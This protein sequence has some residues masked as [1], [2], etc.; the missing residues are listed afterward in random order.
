MATRTSPAPKGNSSGKSGS[1]SARGSGPAAAKTS[2]AGGTKAPRAPGSW[3]PSNPAA[4]AGP[5][6][7]PAP[8]WASPTSSGRVSGGSAT[9]SATSPPRTAATAPPCSTWRWRL[10]RHLRLVG[11]PGWFPDI[12]YAVVNGTFGWMSLV[13][14]LMLF[15]C[16]FRLFRQPVDGRGN[17]R[18]GIGF[19]IMTFAGSGLAHVIGGQPT[20]ADGFDGLRQAGG[21]L[22]FLAAAPLAAIHAAVP[23]AVYGLLAFVSLLIVT[24]TPF[25]AIPGRLR[26]AYEHLMGIDLQDHGRPTATATTAATSTKTTP[27][28]RRRRSAAASSARTRTTTP[29]SKATSATR[30]SNVRSSPTRKPRPPGPPVAPRPAPSRRQTRRA[31]RAPPHPGRDRRRKDQGRPGPRNRRPQRGRTPPRRS[32]SS[33]RA[34]SPPV[35]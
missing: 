3:P 11:L 2:R 1:S 31:R 8:G 24:A 26:G 25:G 9:T 33:P 13:L 12:V 19:L 27:R 28:P 15:V 6:C 23:V 17:N 14:P 21:M 4:L 20:V 32:R 18:V 7:W 29:G 16:A 34:W 30:P 22:G 5:G 35:R 10:R